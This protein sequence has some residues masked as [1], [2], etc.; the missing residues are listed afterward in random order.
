MKKLNKKLIKKTEECQTLDSKYLDQ[1]EKNKKL[2]KENQTLK[3]ERDKQEKKI[4][5][6]RHLTSN[7]RNIVDENISCKED[8]TKSEAEVTELKDRNDKLT[9]AKK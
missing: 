5:L 6:L 3:S 1:L 9:E 4:S 7:I 2:M 8:L